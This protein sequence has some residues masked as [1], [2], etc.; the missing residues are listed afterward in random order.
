MLKERMHFA[1][2]KYFKEYIS[3]QKKVTEFCSRKLIATA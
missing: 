3:T 1:I 2:L